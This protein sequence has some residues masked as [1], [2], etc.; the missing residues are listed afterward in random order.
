MSLYYGHINGF[1]YFLQVQER[2][3]NIQKGRN[4]GGNLIWQMGEKVCQWEFTLVDDGRNN[5]ERDCFAKKS[6]I[7]NTFS[8]LNILLTYFYRLKC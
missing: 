2:F 6:Y 5:Y 3:K 4:F 8:G 7:R 1:K